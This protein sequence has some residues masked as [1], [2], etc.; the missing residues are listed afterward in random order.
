MENG[1]KALATEPAVESRVQRML[2]RDGGVGG[3]HLLGDST[4]ISKARRWVRGGGGTPA[5]NHWSLAPPCTH[6]A[7]PLPMEKLLHLGFLG[8][9]VL[10]PTGDESD[11]CI[12]GMHLLLNL[13]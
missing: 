13:S 2:A 1:W 7:L 4:L 5:I 12:S 10:P 3:D 6:P 9:V 8:L 11:F